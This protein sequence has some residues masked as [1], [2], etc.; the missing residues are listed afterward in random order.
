MPNLWHNQ[1]TTAC[2]VK[3]RDPQILNRKEYTFIFLLR[4]TLKM[5]T[6]ISLISVVKMKPLLKLKYQ[7]SW[8]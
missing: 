6:D 1:A 3:D 4:Y 8:L 2:A 5:N 7:K